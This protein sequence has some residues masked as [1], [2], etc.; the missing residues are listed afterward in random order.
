MKKS[1]QRKMF[2]K[3]RTS[4]PLKESFPLKPKRKK[5]NKEKELTNFSDLLLSL[6]V[7]IPRN[8]CIVV[9]TETI[10]D[11]SLD[12]FFADRRVTENGQKLG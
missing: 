7:A 10:G 8:K 5:K 6:A 2:V 9:P 1:S 4:G 11:V 3:I 12:P